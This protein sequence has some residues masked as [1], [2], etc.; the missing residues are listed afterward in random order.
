MIKITIDFAYLWVLESEKEEAM[1]ENALIKRGE[2]RRYFLQ[3]EC[4]I[5]P[6]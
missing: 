2:V 4:Q 3:Y 6:P 5:S 1:N